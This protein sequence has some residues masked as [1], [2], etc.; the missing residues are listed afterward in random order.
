MNKRKCVMSQIE[1]KEKFSKCSQ[2]CKP[3][4]SNKVI[5]NI[6]KNIHNPELIKNLKLNQKN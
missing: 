3:H 1:N 4:E 5:W 6:K 2:L